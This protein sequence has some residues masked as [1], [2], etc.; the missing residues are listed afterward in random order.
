MPS[1]KHQYRQR[2]RRTFHPP[3]LFWHKLSKLWLTKSA[4]REVNRRNKLLPPSQSSFSIPYTFAPDFLRNCSATC[5][6]EIRKLS[7][8]GGPDLSDIRNYPAPAL[9]SMLY[10]PHQLQ[11]ETPYSTH[12][13]SKTGSTTVYDPHFENHLTNHGIFMPFSTYPDVT[14]PSKPENIAEIRKRL[15]APRPS[16]ALSEGPLEREYEDFIRLN[17]D[18]GDEQVVITEILPSGGGHLFKNLAPLTDGTLADAKPDLYH[19]AQ[20]NQLEP[21][22]LTQLD[23]QIT[24]SIQSNRPAAPNFFIEAKGHDRSV[25]VAMRQACYEGA[26]GARAMHSLQRLGDESEN[27]YD[28]K[29]YTMMSTYHTG[30]LAMYA[31]HPTSPESYQ[32]GLSAYRNGRDLAKEYRDGFIKQA[33][34]DMQ[35]AKILLPIIMMDLG[36]LCAFSIE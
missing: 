4:L 6:Q 17:D 26:L 33:N 25:R 36:K 14:E 1:F 35:L 32:Q 28:D 27:R 5:L 15:R 8:C 2:K 7:R 31:T 20:P 19:G 30:T 23:N 21:A 13:K 11:L 29:A 12:T 10:G 3:P 22:I 16:V 9:L 18:A 34:G 24:P